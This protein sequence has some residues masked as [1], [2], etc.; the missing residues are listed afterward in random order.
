MINQI[1]NY[2]KYLLQEL[3]LSINTVNSYLKDLKSFNDYL[4]K[5]N[6]NFLKITRSEVQGYL[7]FLANKNLS[8]STISRKISSLRGFYNYLIHTNL[9][10]HN[11]F[12]EIKNPKIKR[13]LP[14]YLNYKEMREIIDSIDIKTNEGILER[15][16]IEIFYATGVRV[17]ELANIKNKDIDLNNLTIRIKGKGRKERIVFFGDYALE[18]LNNYYKKVYYDRKSN[19]DYLFIKESGEPFTIFEIENIVKNIVKNLPIKNNVT[20]HTFRHTFATHLLNNGADIKTVQELLGHSNL[21]TTAIY[22][23][24]SNEKLRE[25]YLKTFPR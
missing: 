5:N 13:K 9:I 10:N 22:T 12:N 23:H 16:I 11:V 19:N 14:N 3:N 17:S 1:E 15:L 7:K 24:L 8:N 6:I 21:N 2:S 4:L 25:V 18:A 20:P